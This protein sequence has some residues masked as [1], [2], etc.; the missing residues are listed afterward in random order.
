MFA[1]KRPA[2]AYDA[3]SDRFGGVQLNLLREGRGPVEEADFEELA[4]AAAKH[5]IDLTAHRGFT[6]RP[7]GAVELSFDEPA[8]A[9]AAL[10]A[11]GV[12][13]SFADAEA[14]FARLLDARLKAAFGPFLTMVA[15]QG[16]QVSV[17]L[18]DRMNE[19]F[20]LWRDP[21]PDGGAVAS[22]P[23]GAGAFIFA[24]SHDA[25]L[26]VS[27]AAHFAGRSPREAMGEEAYAA[28][29]EEFRPQQK[30]TS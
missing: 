23:G 13:A 17:V 7:D 2:L 14:R 9:V 22:A 25:W 21:P 24:N 4:R 27:Q 30:P 11:I 16:G 5:G 1:R 3:V 10:R 26:F 29:Q 20:E 12:E 19:Y 15:G 8:A 28:A 6:A 18:D